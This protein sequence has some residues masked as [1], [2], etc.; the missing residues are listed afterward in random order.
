MELND[1]LTLQKTLK[2]T[3]RREQ[4][5]GGEQPGACSSQGREEPRRTLSPG[6]LIRGKSLPVVRREVITSPPPHYCYCNKAS[7]VPEPNTDMSSLSSRRSPNC[8]IR[9]FHLAIKSWMGSS[10][11]WLFKC[12]ALYAFQ[13]GLGSILRGKWLGLLW[14]EIISLVT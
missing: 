5:V 6:F 14:T 8:W 4:R 2:C 10:L 7:S 9:N 3:G 13:A 1:L 12:E 11:H